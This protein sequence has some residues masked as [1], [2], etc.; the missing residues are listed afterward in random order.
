[1]FGILKWIIILGLIGTVWFVYDLS[2]KLSPSD[3][4]ALKKDAIEALDTGNM[5]PLNTNIKEKVNH[6]LDE[7][8][9]SLFE[10]IRKKLRG[11]FED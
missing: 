6:E 3:K 8:K 5:A 4:E 2:T 7:K 9:N 1:M 10:S 11:L